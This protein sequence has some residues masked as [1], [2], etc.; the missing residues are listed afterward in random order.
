MI[1]SE[2]LKVTIWNFL[3]T[4]LWIWN[5]STKTERMKTFYPVISSLKMEK[6]MEIGSVTEKGICCT[7]NNFSCDIITAT[8]RKT[9]LTVT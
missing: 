4:L 3:F 8:A 9:I 7:N 1:L 2:M 6:A 5:S